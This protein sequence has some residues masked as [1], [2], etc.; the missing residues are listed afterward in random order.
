MRTLNNNMSAT[1]NRKR[2]WLKSNN[3]QSGVTLI[4][5][6]VAMLIL[7]FG[8]LAIVNLQTASAI[9]IGSSADHFKINELSQ[10]IAEQLKADSG[11]A[12]A[13]D[14][15]TEYEQ[16]GAPPGA[17]PEVAQRINSWKQSIARAI[18]LGE[19]RIECTSTE[20][21]VGLRWHE[22]SHDGTNSQSFNTNTPL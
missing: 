13:G 21:A 16:T 5:V 10:V 17:A 4:E 22:N 7:T 18:P 12:A 3:K 20:C 11:R 2:A 6:T 14:Y 15:N 1:T 19:A 9:A 8:A